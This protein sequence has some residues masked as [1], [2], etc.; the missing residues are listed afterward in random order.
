MYK[1]QIQNPTWVEE[2]F[3]NALLNYFSPIF[4]FYIRIRSWWGSKGG[5]KLDNINQ[6]VYKPP[7]DG[8]GWDG[9]G[10]CQIVDPI[11]TYQKILAGQV[12]FPAH[13][14]RRFYAS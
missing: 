14:S 5:R 2:I 1:I 11:G 12:Q 8:M 13:F 3:F 4:Y 10:G 6:H 9:W 7:W